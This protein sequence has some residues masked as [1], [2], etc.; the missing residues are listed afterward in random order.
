VLLQ[1]GG[2]PAMGRVYGEH[3]ADHVDRRGRDVAPP[4]LVEV[5]LPALDLI[6]QRLLVFLLKRRTPTEHDVAD[7][8]AAPYVAGGG[9]SAAQQHLGGHVSWGAQGRLLL[10][11]VRH[12]LGE[13]KVYKFDD[14]IFFTYY[15]TQTRCGE[16]G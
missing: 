5:V 10:A 12:T 7:H 11:H 6:E 16:A 3:S 4:A 9:V 13:P 14:S 15:T 8:T 2:S 1:L